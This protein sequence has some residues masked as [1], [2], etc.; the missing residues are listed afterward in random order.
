MMM[1][2]STSQA[3]SVVEAARRIYNTAQPT[4]DQV[5][6]TA[7]K[8]EEGTL[9]RG[10]RGGMTTTADAV[11]EYMA[12]RE[13]ARTNAH[14][15][16]PDA[17]AVGTMAVKHSAAFSPFYRHVLKDYFLAVVLRRKVANRSPVFHRLVLAGQVVLLAAMLGLFVTGAVATLRTGLLP[18][19]HR[20]VQ[21][22]LQTKYTEVDVDRFQTLP[23]STV[24]VH[25]RYKTNRRVIHSEGVFKVAGGR[26]SRVIQE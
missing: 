8:I 23:D 1:P 16:Q 14:L 9:A 20:A 6:R 19:D 2:T 11:A 4:L 21:A 18:E 7:K 17:D 25:F 24:R 10:P 15:R 3:I 26:V 12:R 5:G 13:A 22:W